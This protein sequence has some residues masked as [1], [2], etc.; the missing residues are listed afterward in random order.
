[1]FSRAFIEPVDKMPDT[2]SE[3][4]GGITL[5]PSPYKVKFVKR[6]A[7]TALHTI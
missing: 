7:S 1:V 4:D 5:I 2:E 3:I 6:N